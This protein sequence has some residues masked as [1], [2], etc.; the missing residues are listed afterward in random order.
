[1]QADVSIVQ[2]LSRRQAVLR[3]VVCEQESCGRA[4]PAGVSPAEQAG[5]AFGR[6]CQTVPW[7]SG[8]VSTVKTVISCSS[9]GS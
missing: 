6:H 1:M 4:L 3:V 5:P 2:L 8:P 9:N 7:G